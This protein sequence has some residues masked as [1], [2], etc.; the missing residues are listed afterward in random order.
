MPN[1][2]NR[3]PTALLLFTAI[4]GLVIGALPSACTDAGCRTNSQQ[5]TCLTCHCTCHVPVEASTVRSTSAGTTVQSI[6]LVAA[7]QAPTALLRNPEPPP[8]S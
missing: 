4:F 2:R 5:S 3:V 7:T 8:R 1:A 6:V